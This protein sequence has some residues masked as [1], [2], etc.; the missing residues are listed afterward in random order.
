MKTKFTIEELR[1]MIAGS[2]VAPLNGHILGN[3]QGS[4]GKN[5]APKK[6]SKYKNQKVVVDGLTFDSKKEANRYFE[7]KCLKAS[8]AIYNLFTQVEF[9]L[10][11]CIY[12]AD[13]TYQKA[14]TH[15]LVVEDVK[16]AATRKLSTYRLKKKLLKAEKGIEIKEI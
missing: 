3:E 14:D 13:F 15:E 1:K 7:L 16:S 11:V 5:K 2:P 12:R 9:Q 10:S 4:A 6:G 8:G